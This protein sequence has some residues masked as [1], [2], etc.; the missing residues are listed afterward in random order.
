MEFDV[1]KC[2]VMQVAMN[3]SNCE[4]I[5]AGTVYLNVYLKR[6]LKEVPL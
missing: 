6:N 3:N 5:M 4:Y 1:K 2:K